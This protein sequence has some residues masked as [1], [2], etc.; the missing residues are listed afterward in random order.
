MTP[1][2]SIT[3]VIRTY[4]FLRWEGLVASLDSVYSQTLKPSQVVVVVDHNPDLLRLVKKHFPSAD[5]VEN[6]YMQGSSGAWNS[7]VLAAIG[8]IIAFMDDDAVAEPDWLARLVDLYR[9]SQVVGVGGKIVPNWLVERPVWFPEEFDWVV[10]CTYKGLPDSAAPVRNLIGCNM[11]FRLSVFDTVGG[12]RN[13]MGHVGSRPIGCDETE[14]CIR[15]RQHQPES[16]LLYEPRAVVNHTVPP[17]R[18]TFRYFVKRCA[19][20][21]NS[22]ALVARYVGAHDGLA[23]ERSH[24]FKV[25]PQAVKEN[26]KDAITHMKFSGLVKAA[27]VIIGFTITAT[28]YLVGTFTLR[29]TDDAFPMKQKA[30]D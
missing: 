9:E 28:T 6:R 1:I 15:L 23:A 5:V 14:M 11:S 27:V 25:L 7:G 20:E 30:L 17:D 18:A 21:G 29:S 4:S 24:A 26:L 3:V 22:K 19:L 10:G 8:E 2:K 12:F 16:I 13:G